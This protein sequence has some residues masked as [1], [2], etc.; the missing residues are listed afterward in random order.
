MKKSFILLLLL[1][2]SLMFSGCSTSG[3]KDKTVVFADAGWDSI[4]LHNAVAGYVLEKGFGFTW[5]QVTGSTAITYQALKDGEIDVYME[6]WTDNLAPYNQDL[7]AGLFD[8]YGVNYD[9]N[10]QGLYVPRYVIEGDAARGIVASAPSLVTVADLK[11]YPEVFKDDEDP[12]KGRVYGGI[13]GWEVDKILFNKYN[14]YGLDENFVYFRPGS[15]AALTSVL[16][17]AYEK[18]DAIVGYY[19]DPTWMLAKYDFVKLEDAPYSEMDFKEGKTAFAAVKVT[20]AARKDFDTEYP[21]AAAFLKKYSTTSALNS[22][23]LLHMQET[24]DNVV[25]TSIWFMKQHPELLTAWLNAKELAL[26]NK[27]LEAE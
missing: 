27:A 14:Y 21:D 25:K 10:A 17:A 6:V 16:S 15:E 18:G 20:V 4:Q 23:M 11:N 19:W 24:G 26:V 2:L 12:S 3:T 22:Q 8:E 5:S 13:P 9:D 7:A 1:S